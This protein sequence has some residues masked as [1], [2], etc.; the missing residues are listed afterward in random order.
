M[1]SNKS[2][3]LHPVLMGQ[4][5]RTVGEGEGVWGGGGI[6]CYWWFFLGG[7]RDGLDEVGM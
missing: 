4:S 5:L 3:P 2:R 7:F 1:A 6:S